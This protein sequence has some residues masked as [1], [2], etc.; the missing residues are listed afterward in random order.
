MNIESK[1]Q[2]CTYPTVETMAN[3]GTRT[4]EASGHCRPS[5]IL[6]SPSLVAA[7][8]EVKL[9]ILYWPN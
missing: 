6:T 7:M 5:S 8:I 9:R 4:E 3:A 2:K 1:A